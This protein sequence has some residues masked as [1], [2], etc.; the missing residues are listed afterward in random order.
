MSSAHPLVRN[1]VLDA[2]KLELGN[3]IQWL[4]W[5]VWIRCKPA[6]GEQELCYI[7]NF[8][9]SAGDVSLPVWREDDPKPRSRYIP[10]ALPLPGMPSTLLPSFHTFPG[11][12]PMSMTRSPLPLFWRP[13]TKDTLYQP[14]YSILWD[15]ID[16]GSLFLSKRLQPI[17]N[18][19]P[20]RCRRIIVALSPSSRLLPTGADELSNLSQLGPAISLAITIHPLKI[21]PWATLDEPSLIQNLTAPWA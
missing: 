19:P 10:N 6:C 1:A 5:S 13:E 12:S 15:N 2:W 8:P 7:P 16:L 20:S 17:Q 9:F 18:E 21:S 11:R 4:D 14:L 3:L